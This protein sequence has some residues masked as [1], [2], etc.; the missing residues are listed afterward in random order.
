MYTIQLTYHDNETVNVQLKDEQLNG[1]YS[2]LS[3][4][5]LFWF[6][7]DIHG[8]WTDLDKVRCVQV[9]KTEDDGKIVRLVDV[10]QPIAQCDDCET[11]DEEV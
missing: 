4:K 6:S 1:F 9:F 11:S 7:E 8:F 10:E 3:A 5:S 2:S